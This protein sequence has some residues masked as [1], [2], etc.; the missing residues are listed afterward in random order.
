LGVVRLQRLT[1]PLVNRD[2]DLRRW[3]RTF[4]DATPIADLRARHVGT[5]VGVVKRI[6][7]V[8][9]ALLEVAVE[10]GTGDLVAAWPGRTH[11]RGVDLGS[12]LRLTGTVASDGEGRRR[13]LN[14]AWQLVGEPYA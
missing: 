12:A 9:G 7:V 2:Q 3:Q 6:R 8:P 4:D 1:D 11:L 5:A 13:M 14:P 10:D